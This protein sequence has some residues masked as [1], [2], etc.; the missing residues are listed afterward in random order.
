MFLE[1]LKFFS[2]GLLDEILA[3][4]LGIGGGVLI[5]PVLNI[6]PMSELRF[7]LQYL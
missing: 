7:Q 3:G 6:S 5:I 1:Y 4:L 2:I